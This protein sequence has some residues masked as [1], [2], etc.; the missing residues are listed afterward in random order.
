MEISGAVS[1]IPSVTQGGSVATEVQKKVEEVQE[2]TAETLIK[3][4]PD[5]DSSL[6]QNIDVKA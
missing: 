5:L 6:G 4:L 2:Q 3:S 1:S